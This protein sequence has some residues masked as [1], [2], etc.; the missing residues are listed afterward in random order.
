VRLT[1]AAAAVTNL[2]FDPCIA[3]LLDQEPGAPLR[4]AF[5]SG[6]VRTRGDAIAGKLFGIML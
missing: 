4:E 2:R 5:A 6:K 1:A 3:F